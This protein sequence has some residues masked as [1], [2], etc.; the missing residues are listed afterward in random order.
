MTETVCFAVTGPKD[1]V[2]DDVY[3]VTYQNYDKLAS[4]VY[5]KMEN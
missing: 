5:P 4:L 2:E 3:E 1:T